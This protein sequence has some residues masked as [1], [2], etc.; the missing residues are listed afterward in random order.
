MVTVKKN[1]SEIAAE[2]EAAQTALFDKH[3]V[4]FAFSKK[5]LEE[6]A[7][8]GVEYCTVLGCG[9]VCP[10][11]N[12]KQFLLDLADINKKHRAEMV[13]N[14]GKKVLIRHELFNHECFYTGDITDA[15]EALEGYEI[16]REEVYAEYCHI[17][18][19]EDVEC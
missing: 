4:F 15:V 11:E 7:L 9:D 10:K 5:Q 1:R 18:A 19:T 16:T 13:E 8:P 6:K 14:V 17:L 3:G 2:H 12:A